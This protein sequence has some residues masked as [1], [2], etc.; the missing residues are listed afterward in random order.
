M[1]FNTYQAEDNRH[2]KSS[3][4]K[5]INDILETIYQVMQAKRCLP[6]YFLIQMGLLRR[7]LKIKANILLIMMDVFA[8]E[9]IL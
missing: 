9:E 1:K 3:T 8:Q 5:H 7:M 2:F 6:Q 4:G